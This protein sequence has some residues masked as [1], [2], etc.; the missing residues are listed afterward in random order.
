MVP[1]SL[2]FHIPF[3]RKRCSYCDFNTCAGYEDLIPAYISALC[4]E[5]HKVSVTAPAALS[6][7][8]IYFGGG[9]P[10]L[11]AANQVERILQSIRGHFAL[12]DDVEITLE[13]NPGTVSLAQLRDLRSI[14]VNRLS[15][16]MQSAHADELLL[17]ERLHDQQ[18]VIDA[19]KWARQAGFD[20]LSLDLIYGLPDQTLARWQFSL[21]MGL[22]LAPEHLSLYSLTLEPGTRLHQWAS[23]GLVNWPDDD[24]AADMYIWSMERLEGAGYQ[25]YEIS[26]WAREA[27]DGAVLSSRHNLQYWRNHPYL[28]FGSGAHGSAGGVRTAN[29]TEL[30]AYIDKC[31]TGAAGRFPIGPAAVNVIEIDRFNEMQETMMV[32]LRLT[33]EGVSQQGFMTRFGEPMQAVFGKEIDE[34]IGFGLVEWGGAEGDRLRLT[35]RGRPLGNQAFMRF[36]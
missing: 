35:K 27:A 32:G 9:T 10:S 33:E 34:L 12:E 5:I 13:A 2:Y 24:L 31:R 17:L 20:D 15:F 3:C 21:E 7:H 25:Q 18:G 4:T 11:V 16:G 14:G 22:Q 36:V 28:G 29:E 8:T 19:V 6:A 23:R 30:R 1:Y 26:N